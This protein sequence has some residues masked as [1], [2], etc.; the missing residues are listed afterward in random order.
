MKAG[1][2]ECTLTLRRLRS[3]PGIMETPLSV[4]S[5]ENLFAVCVGVADPHLI[6][7]LV[8]TGHD[9][10]GRQHSLSFTFQSLSVKSPPKPG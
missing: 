5:L 8:V 10:Y 3:G 2:H 9:G 1:V 7:R 6:E 4:A